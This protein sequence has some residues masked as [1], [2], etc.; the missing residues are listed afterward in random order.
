[1][2]PPNDDTQRRANTYYAWG[3]CGFLLLAIGLIY[4]Q[5]LGHLLLITTTASLSTE[6]PMSPRA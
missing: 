1:M 3:V 2:R 6:T 4:G 5:T